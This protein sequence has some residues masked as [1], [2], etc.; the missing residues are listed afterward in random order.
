MRRDGEEGWPRGGEEGRA[1]A[2][3]P[4]KRSTSRYDC[5][6][7]AAYSVSTREPMYALVNGSLRAAKA[8]GAGVNHAAQKRQSTER[9]RAGAGAPLCPRESERRLRDGS[10][11]REP[12]R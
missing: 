2:C 3:S 11:A 5:R 6:M 10:V 12:R 9:E 4:I 1:L 8:R 7:K